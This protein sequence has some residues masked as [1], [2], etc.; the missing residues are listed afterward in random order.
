MEIDFSKF[1]SGD[2]VK[3]VDNL[4]HKASGSVGEIRKDRVFVNWFDGY[5][6]WEY[7]DE[8]NLVR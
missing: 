8:V 4:P 2:K 5:G 3:H 7:T 1:F 6:E